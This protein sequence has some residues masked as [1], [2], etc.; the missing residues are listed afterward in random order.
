M[1]GTERLQSTLCGSRRL[2]WHWV[3]KG[4]LRNLAATH[5]SREGDCRLWMLDLPWGYLW[6]ECAFALTCMFT[7]RMNLHPGLVNETLQ[8]TLAHTWRSHLQLWEIWVHAM[9]ML[10]TPAFKACITKGCKLA[11]VLVVLASRLLF[12]GYFWNQTLRHFKTRLQFFSTAD[13]LVSLV[14]CAGLPLKEG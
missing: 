8:V 12:R 11:I 13:P 2:L 14:V 5:Q 9:T 7:L 3:L 4:P 6:A 10:W 1:F